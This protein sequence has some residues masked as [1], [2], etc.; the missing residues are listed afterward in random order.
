MV[1]A[2]S[3]ETDSAL[4]TLA[5]VAATQGLVHPRISGQTCLLEFPH[6]GIYK[7]QAGLA[8]LPSCKGLRVFIPPELLP[9]DAILCK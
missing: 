6:V 9:S 4:R 1:L 8:I 7:R 2:V 3:A 5:Y